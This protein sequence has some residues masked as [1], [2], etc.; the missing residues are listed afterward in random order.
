M[1]THINFRDITER[2]EK[3]ISMWE[4]KLLQLPQDIRTERKN[5]QNRT[6]KEIIG[7]MI[8]SASNNHQRIVRLQY[9]KSL[10]FPDYRQDNDIWITTQNYQEED[11][12]LMIHL[13]KYLNLHMVHIFLNINPDCL[14][15]TWKDHENTV[16]T[17]REMIESYL[18][19][20]ELHLLEISDLI[21]K[22][23][24]EKETGS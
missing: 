4:V 12:S 18:V 14:N 24:T 23:K 22:S 16:I 21:P 9:N 13:W 1:N 11:W 7:H 10:V 15:N 3:L 8:D 19:H 17:L 20:L 2:I 5:S 6:I